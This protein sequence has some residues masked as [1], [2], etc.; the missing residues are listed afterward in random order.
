MKQDAVIFTL[1][2]IMRGADIFADA[3]GA[4]R[5]QYAKP[6]SICESAVAP[7]HPLLPAMRSDLLGLCA[8]NRD[9]L[10]VLL[11]FGG[12]HLCEFFAGGGFS[13]GTHFAERFANFGILQRFHIRLV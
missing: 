11:E 8:G 13:I 12:D 9:D 1:F 4:W 6:L 7:S 3:K 2:D 10:F 5:T